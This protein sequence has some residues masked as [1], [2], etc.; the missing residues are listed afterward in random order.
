MVTGNTVY[1]TVLWCIR[2]WYSHLEVPYLDT[3]HCSLCLKSGRGH[4]SAIVSLIDC[5]V[6][7]FPSGHPLGIHWQYSGTIN[8]WRSDSVTI[9]WL[10]CDMYSVIFILNLSSIS[11]LYML[12]LPL[13]IHV[14]M[15]VWYWIIM[16]DECTGLSCREGKCAWFVKGMRTGSRSMCVWS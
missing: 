12:F 16:N 2:R 13:L 7:I 6:R 11:P 10:S 3:K 14:C 1:H 9:M 5:S 8:H 15:Y 4:T